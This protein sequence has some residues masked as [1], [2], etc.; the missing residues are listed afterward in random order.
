MPGYRGAQDDL[1]AM[2]ELSY[3]FPAAI[4]PDS[5]GTILQRATYSRNLISISSDDIASGY[6]N[7]ASFGLRAREHWDHEFPETSDPP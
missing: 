5:L 4:G 7:L 2:A 3:S 6:H 1:A